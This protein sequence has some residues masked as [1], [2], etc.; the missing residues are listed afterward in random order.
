[1]VDMFEDTDST[2]RSVIA[3]YGSI[4]L[5][6]VYHKEPC[7]NLILKDFIVDGDGLI[8]PAKVTVSK[9]RYTFYNGRGVYKPY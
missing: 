5:A 2:C 1:M 9:L 4:V 6:D 7:G 8:P 3:Q